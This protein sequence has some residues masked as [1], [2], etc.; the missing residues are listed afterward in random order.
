MNHTL[1]AEVWGGI[2]KALI[3]LGWLSDGRRLDVARPGLVRVV[4][5]V[6]G[7]RKP[8][9]TNNNSPQLPITPID[10]VT[11]KLRE[12]WQDDKHFDATPL[13]QQDAYAKRIKMRLPNAPK[14]AQTGAQECAKMRPDTIH[15]PKLAAMLE[16]ACSLRGYD[17][18]DSVGHD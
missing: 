12:T 16:R 10:T 4:G 6:L 3:E 9:A 14:S 7:N 1:A 8:R 15:D 18:D 17:G 2:E 13:P 5:R 11:V